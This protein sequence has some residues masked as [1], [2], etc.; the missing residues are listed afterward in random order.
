MIAQDVGSSQISLPIFKDW[1]KVNLNDIVRLNQADRGIVGGNSERVGARSNDSLV[2]MFLN[3]EFLWR[4]GINLLLY[5]AL[6]TTG[7][8]ESSLFYL[9]E[10]L[11]CP[12]LGDNQ[13]CP[14]TLFGCEVGFCHAYCLTL[15]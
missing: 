12:F 6:V 5:L 10:Q 7:L 8:K 15:F 11:L 4:D 2:P 1:A 9:F 14:P 3:P 13:G